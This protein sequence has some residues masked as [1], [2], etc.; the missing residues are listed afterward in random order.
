MLTELTLRA[1]EDYFQKP[2]DV[3]DELGHIDQEIKQLEQRAR[4][5]KAALI[6]RGQGRYM[7]MRY[8]AEVQE[9]DR[10]SISATLVK[11]FGTKDFVAQVTQMQHIKAVVVKPLLETV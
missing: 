6:E 4:K 9:Y 11:E 2:T 1:V 10:T 8:V 7:G 3:I 5:L